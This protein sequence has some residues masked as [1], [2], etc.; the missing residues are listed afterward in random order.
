[1]RKFLLVV[2]II[3][4]T[5][6]VGQRARDNV[7]MPA[8][9]LAWPGVKEDVERGPVVVD[10]ASFDNSIQAGVFPAYVEW[11]PL[12]SAAYANIDAAQLSEGIKTS[13]RERVRQFDN[14]VRKGSQ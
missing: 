12:Q 14:A 7:L 1:M 8:M 6:C 5:G 3:A 11:S 4:L 9:Q 10:T 2:P 13:R